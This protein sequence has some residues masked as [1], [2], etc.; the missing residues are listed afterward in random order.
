MVSVG[1]WRGWNS[2]DFESRE[3]D[4]SWWKFW[5]A[6]SVAPFTLWPINLRGKSR[7][8]PL[9]HIN[10]SWEFFTRYDLSWYYI[11]ITKIILYKYRM[12]Q[13]VFFGSPTKTL[14][15]Y[16]FLKHYTLSGLVNIRL[17]K[18]LV[19]NLKSGIL[20]IKKF[21]ILALFASSTEY[22]IWKFVTIH[23]SKIVHRPKWNMKKVKI[24]FLQNYSFKATILLVF[25]KF[26]FS[27]AHGL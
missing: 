21:C 11:L 25:I 18:H 4:L 20:W 13:K 14:Q 27:W 15:F 16:F 23:R 6:L 24:Y 10:L 7:I 1:G 19:F 9:S 2:K 22:L 3:L 8:V 26:H 12:M 17:C 5:I